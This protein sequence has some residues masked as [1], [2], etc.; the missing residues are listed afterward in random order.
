MAGM[1]QEEVDRGVASV[2]GC[3]GLR[4]GTGGLLSTCETSL[5]VSISPRRDLL[6]VFDPED[7]RP[8]QIVVDGILRSC[9]LAFNEYTGLS[10]EAKAVALDAIGRVDM[11]TLARSTNAVGLNRSLDS[12]ITGFNRQADRLE[13]P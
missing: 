12:V 3:S 9:G 2:L 11:Q 7:R 5:A 10:P 13:G 8:P 4:A 1:P 6:G